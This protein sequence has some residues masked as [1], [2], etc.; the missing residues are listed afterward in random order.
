MVSANL[1]SVIVFSMTLLIARAVLT[2][3][4]L[5]GRVEGL[6][7]FLLPFAAG[8]FVYIAGCDLVPELLDQ[9]GL[10]TGLSQFGLMALGV[11][12]M[13]LVKLL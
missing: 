5:G 6:T 10:G 13:C 12:L 1:S 8:N 11:L 2:A 3:L 7:G 4:Y 9:K